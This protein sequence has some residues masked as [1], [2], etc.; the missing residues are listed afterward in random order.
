LGAFFPIPHGVVCGTLVAAATRI[1]IHSMLAREPDNKAL[2]KYVH[3][4]E[5]LYQKHYTNSETAFNALVDL[6]TQW[7]DELALPRLSHY[8]L[9]EAALDKVIA[10]CRGSSMKTNPIVLADEEI[11]QVLLERL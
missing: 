7:T 3:A 10:N 8:G 9:Q 4:A 1:N 11:R 2:A 6:L 5:I